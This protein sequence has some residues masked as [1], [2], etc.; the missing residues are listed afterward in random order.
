MKLGQHLHG[1]INSTL[2]SKLTLTVEIAGNQ[3]YCR[4][5]NKSPARDAADNSMSND[6]PWGPD[7]VPGGRLL[8]HVCENY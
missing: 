7:A 4:M 5:D 6:K 3:K 1:H 8:N 2:H